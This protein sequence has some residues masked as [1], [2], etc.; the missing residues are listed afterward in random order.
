MMYEEGQNFAID[1]VAFPLVFGSPFCVPT[2]RLLRIVEE[3][4]N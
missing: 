3:R 2:A 1:L 4:P